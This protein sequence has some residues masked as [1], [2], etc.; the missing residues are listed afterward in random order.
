MNTHYHPKHGVK[1]LTRY[2]E[3]TVEKPDGTKVSAA[4]SDELPLCREKVETIYFNIAKEDGAVQYVPIDKDY[5][6][7][8]LDYVKDLENKETYTTPDLT[9]K[10]ILDIRK[11]FA[12]IR[13]GN[14]SDLV[15]EFMKNNTNWKDNAP[16]D[17]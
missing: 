5:L 7:S 16:F 14:P 3:V 11:S 12:N 13:A 10:Q 4:Y 2:V 1:Y 15:E 17:I 8:V 6:L 9:E